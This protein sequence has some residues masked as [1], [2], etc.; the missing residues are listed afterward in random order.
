[1]KDRVIPWRDIRVTLTFRKNFRAGGYP[2][3][4]Q[5]EVL[6]VHGAQPG[7]VLQGVGAH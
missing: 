4:A 2:D 5:G 6:E 1:M 7:A 3:V